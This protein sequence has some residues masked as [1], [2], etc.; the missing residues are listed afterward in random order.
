MDQKERWAELV[1]TLASEKDP[2]K[3]RLACEEIDQISER[4]ETESLV[5]KLPIQSS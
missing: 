1:E 3:G 2:E 4:R 5:K